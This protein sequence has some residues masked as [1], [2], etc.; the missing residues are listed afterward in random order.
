MQAHGS[1]LAMMS[2]SNTVLGKTHGGL[3]AVSCTGDF[4]DAVVI[5]NGRRIP[6]TELWRS[7]TEEGA[8]RC[9][10]NVVA[11][12]GEAGWLRAWNAPSRHLRKWAA[13]GNSG[14]SSGLD[15]S[16]TWRH[17]ADRTEDEGH[18]NVAIVRCAD[19]QP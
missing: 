19:S 5:A 12:S 3:R 6:W 15:P 14:Y 11:T 1:R 8:V 9:C 13:D 7:G 17:R 18:S 2:C 16:L 4:L 10:L